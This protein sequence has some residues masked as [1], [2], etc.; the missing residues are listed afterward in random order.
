MA[1][2]E[3][4]ARRTRRYC[5]THTRPNWTRVLLPDRP[6]FT[7][8]MGAM[9]LMPEPVGPSFQ[10]PFTPF[11]ELRPSFIGTAGGT[12]RHA[13]TTGRASAGAR[14]KSWIDFALWWVLTRMLITIASHAHVVLSASVSICSAG[15]DFPQRPETCM[16]P[17]F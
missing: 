14:V 8:M 11:R 10:S 4:T 17:W 9:P 16:A 5:S 6:A 2:P 1:G 13:R 12:G 15:C 3:W 7:M